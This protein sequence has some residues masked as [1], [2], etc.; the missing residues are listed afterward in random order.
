MGLLRHKDEG[1]APTRFRMQQR[2]LSVG[3]DYWIEDEQGNR[4]YLVD[5]KALRL[6]DT[7]V[8][9]DVQD[10]EVATIRERKLSVRE[11]VG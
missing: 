4:C 2:L 7:W 5:G 10:H 11:G 6:R 8:L 1:P 9:K 3:D